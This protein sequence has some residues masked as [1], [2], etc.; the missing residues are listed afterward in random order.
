MSPWW[1][2]VKRA[3]MHMVD[4]NREAL[5][6]ASRHP[7]EFNQIGHPA[8]HCYS[9][10]FTEQP[11]PIIAAMLGDFVHNLRS[12]LD[13]IIVACVPRGRQKSASFPILFEDIFATGNDAKRREGFETA[14]RGLDQ[15]ARG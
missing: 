13:Y 8:T 15:E 5:R 11:N 7:Y 3:Q 2:K 9:M 1:L 14:I 4:I 12:A 6:Y 10:R